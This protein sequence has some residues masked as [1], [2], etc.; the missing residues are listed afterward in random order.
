MESDDEESQTVEEVETLRG[1]K[2]PCEQTDE[3]EEH[4]HEQVERSPKQVRLHLPLGNDD[5]ESSADDKA[6]DA[7]EDGSVEEDD[8][9]ED[10]ATMK[11]VAAFEDDELR[12][13][14]GEEAFRAMQAVQEKEEEDGDGE[15]TADEGVGDEE[16]P[17]TR[18]Y[19]ESKGSRRNPTGPRRKGHR[20]HHNAD[21]YDSISL[22]PKSLPHWFMK[23]K[24]SAIKA[25]HRNARRI[26][27]NY[28]QLKIS[29]AARL[30]CRRPEVLK[31]GFCRQSLQIYQSK[32]YT[33]EFFTDL[34]LRGQSEYVRYLSGLPHPRTKEDHD[35]IPAPTIE[36]LKGL[37]IY[38]NRI[39]L[40]GRELRYGGSG[41][42]KRGGGTRLWQYNQ[43]VRKYRAGP[44][45]VLASRIENHASAMLSPGSRINLRVIASWSQTEITP[46][47]A[48][49][50]E[51][52]QVD[53]EGLMSDS[54]PEQRE[55]GASWTWQNFHSQEIVD[56]STRAFPHDESTRG[57]FIGLN[58][59]SPLAQGACVGITASRRRTCEAFNWKCSV[60]CIAKPGPEGGRQICFWKLAVEICFPVADATIIC[61]QCVKN[62]RKVSEQTEEAALAL[63]A[64]YVATCDACQTVM[65]K[66][67]IVD[68]QISCAAWN[69]RGKNPHV[70]LDCGSRFPVKG[71]LD[72]HKAAP[73]ACAYAVANRAKLHLQCPECD[74]E[75]CR[76]LVGLEDHML[77]AH[78]IAIVSPSGYP[79]HVSGKTTREWPSYQALKGYEC[80]DC[81]REGFPALSALRKHILQVH[82]IRISTVGESVVYVSGAEKQREW[83]HVEVEVDERPPCPECDKP[84]KDLPRLKAHLKREHQIE[85]SIKKGAYT[86]KSG[87]KSK[88][89]DGDP[90]DE[91]YTPVAPLA[92]V[93]AFKCPIPDCKAYKSKSKTPANAL[94]GHLKG[95]HK[96]KVK[97][98]AG[99]FS[100]EEGGQ[101]K[102]FDTN[103]PPA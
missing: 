60:C 91:Q 74:I 89:W 4:S 44:Q 54:V 52:A 94:L 13:A 80:P 85:I 8:D 83:P 77:E 36:Q 53:L 78:K 95:F 24:A 22:G 45:Q 29:Q 90:D 68:H 26:A 92:P 67:D 79:E 33:A 18:G 58:R 30:D 59:A 11:A 69:D 17:Q 37:I 72:D 41:T 56:I 16:V 96:L 42:S 99:V 7:G 9:E 63:M 12:Q 65:H 57:T 55:A 39:E 10:A 27:L 81:L 100:W 51:T 20:I 87:K 64:K 40:N 31:Y 103:N 43:W 70:C 28:F 48:I 62:W 98:K 32:M 15:Y 46:P 61:P 88:R 3:T 102:T 93:A 35:A 75:P 21:N 101:P 73:R 6:S 19:D 5:D 47:L 82:K 1:T 34:W 84:Q 97:E 86:L 50:M 71:L 14:V 76:S 38:G 49:I 23:K 2:R 66:R 25:A